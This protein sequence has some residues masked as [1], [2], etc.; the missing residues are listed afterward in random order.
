M[1]CRRTSSIPW[2]RPAPPMRAPVPL[3]SHD[4]YE[5][6]LADHPIR[7]IKH[8]I[9]RRSAS[10]GED[11]PVPGAPGADAAPG[12]VRRFRHAD[13]D[14]AGRRRCRPAPPPRPPGSGPGIGSSRSTA[15]DFDPMQLPVLCHKNAGK[16]MTFEVERA[17]ADGGRKAQ[18]L[19]ATPD[20][21]PPWTW[22]RA[23][24]GGQ[25]PRPGPVL[26]GL[27]QRRLGEGRARPRPARA[28]SPA[29][30]SI[31]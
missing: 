24:P 15:E 17:A 28:S 11:G 31:P 30:S 8:L 20:A 26:S 7:P 10:S 19:T 2:R 9:E 4:E 23:E 3:G 13:D 18:T 22:T 25:R 14:R 1:P 12:E 16:P 29:T 5:R 6:L 27:A 21:S